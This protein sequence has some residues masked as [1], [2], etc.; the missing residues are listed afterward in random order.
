MFI[1]EEVPQT[2]DDSIFAHGPS[3]NLKIANYVGQSK[4]SDNIEACATHFGG[5]SK[6]LLRAHTSEISADF[7]ET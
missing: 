6:A 4:Q 5:L 7:H 1:S 3:G 2:S